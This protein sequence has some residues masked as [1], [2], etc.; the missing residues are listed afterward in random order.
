MGQQQ[1]LFIILVI[2]IIGVA[3]FVALGAIDE[4]N[5][6]AG[7][8]AIRQDIL[9]AL[10]DA[11]AYYYKPPNMGGGGRSFQELSMEDLSLDNS[12]IN[13]QYILTSDQS[14]LTLVG[15]NPTLDIRIEARAKMSAKGS[16]MIAWY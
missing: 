2:I 15:I 9:R 8:E 12:A 14:S 6:G 7:K 10:G 16:M 5:S 13:G 3:T 4:T 11:Q 1:H